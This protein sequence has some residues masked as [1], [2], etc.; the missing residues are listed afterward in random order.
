MSHSERCFSGLQRGMLIPHSTWL[1][2]APLSLSL[3]TYGIRENVSLSA[4]RGTA[5]P[6]HS[7]TVKGNRE[8]C[9]W[10]FQFW[11]S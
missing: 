11:L 5:L 7:V 9:F 6:N 8:C 10:V 1:S 2:Y 3:V 4:S